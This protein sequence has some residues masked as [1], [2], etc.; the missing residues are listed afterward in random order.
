M[1]F[2]PSKCQVLQITRS[3]KPVMSRYFMHK[4]EL[5]SVD[6]AKYLRVKVSKDLGW[7]NHINKIAASAN[8]TLGFVKRNVQTNKK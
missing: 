1:E 7:N 3:R 8:R 2:N 4:R 6:T 5:E